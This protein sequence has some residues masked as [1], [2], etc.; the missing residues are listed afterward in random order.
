MNCPY[1]AG[2]YCS[3]WLKTGPVGVITSTMNTAFETG[4]CV[5]SDLSSG[6]L[7]VSSEQQG[8][9]AALQLLNEKGK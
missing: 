8:R 9:E 4:K 2:L 1:D 6:D 3:G 5:V 7:T